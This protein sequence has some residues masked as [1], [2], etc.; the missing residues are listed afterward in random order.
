MEPAPLT[1]FVGLSLAPRMSTLLGIR[2]SINSR[3]KVFE[4]QRRYDEATHI[5]THADLG[6][7]WFEDLGKVGADEGVRRSIG[8]APAAEEAHSSARLKRVWSRTSAPASM[9]AGSVRSRTLWLIPSTLGTK[10]IPVGQRGANICA[11]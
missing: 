5:L 6:G 7:C 10:I 11:S 2:R 9:W 3:V 8:S 4:N 1:P